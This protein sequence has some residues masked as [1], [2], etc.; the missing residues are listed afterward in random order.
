MRSLIRFTKVACLIAVV[1]I[2]LALASNTAVCQVCLNITFDPQT[3]NFPHQGGNSQVYVNGTPPSGWSYCAFID[4]YTADTWISGFY[5]SYYW[6]GTTI[7]YTVD[8][9]IGQDRTGHVWFRVESGSWV[10][11]TIHQEASTCGNSSCDS[12]SGETAATCYIDCHCGDAVCDEAVYEDHSNCPQDCHCGDGLCDYGEYDQTCPA[13]C[14]CGNGTCDYG[15]DD[16][17]CDDDCHCGNGTCESGKGENASSCFTDCHCGNGIC[18]SGIENA[19]TCYTDCHCPDGTCEA[20][21]DDSCCHADCHCGNELCELSMGEHNNTC[22]AD[23]Y[24]GDGVC[25]STESHESCATDCPY[26]CGDGICQP[27]LGED[28][29]ACFD[30]CHCGDGNCEIALGEDSYNCYNDCLYCGDE[31]CTLAEFYPF[32]CSLD[33]PTLESCNLPLMELCYYVYNYPFSFCLDYCCQ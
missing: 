28:Y 11:Y 32:G 8:N 22:S 15:E 20:G 12:G 24:C 21:E 3:A 25:D 31:V 18:D 1:C 29:I 2:F 17:N 30:D 14:Y 7:Y 5:Y 33:C 10:P 19:S 9:N 16:N 23:C 27:S 26:Y 6:S 4:V 13:D